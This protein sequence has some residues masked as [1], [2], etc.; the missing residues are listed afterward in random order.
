MQAGDWRPYADKL[1]K[2]ADER[3]LQFVQAHAPMGSPLAKNGQYESFMQLTKQ[4]IEAAAYLGIP[5][6]V[7]HSG[8]VKDMSKEETFKKNV[9]FY[10]ELLRVA[11]KC[12][13]TVLTENFNKMVFPDYYWIDSAEA[14]LE[15]VERVNHPLLQACWDVGH[16]NLQ[17]LSQH[18]ALG[19]LGSHVRGVHIQDNCGNDDTHFMP[20]HRVR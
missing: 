19:L 11:E 17:E 9:L 18:E 8:Y 3:G 15:L 12:N 4:S 7:V 6:I 10:E 1:L 20:Y 16:G 5:N 2:L 14:E 13:I